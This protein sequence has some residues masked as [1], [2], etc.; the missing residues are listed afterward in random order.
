M[1]ELSLYPPKKHVKCAKIAGDTSGNYHPHGEAVIYPTLVHM[2]Q[3]WAMRETLDRSAGELRLGGRRPSGGHALHRGAHDASRRHADAGH[4]EGHGR[5]RAQLRRAPHRADR[6]SRRRSRTSSSMAAPA[7]RSAWRRTCRRTTSAKSST[8]VCAQIDNPEITADGAHGAHQG[9]GLPHGLHHS[10]HQAAS[11][12]TWRPATARCASAA[13]RR[14]SRTATA[15]RS[16]SPRSRYNVNR[17]ELVEAHRRSWR[18]RRSSRKSAACATSR[19]RTS[20]VVVD[21][22][23]DARAAGGAQ[24]PLQ[25]H[26]AGDLASA[27]TC[28]RS[29][30]AR[31]R[32]LS[33]KDAIACY[34]EH[35]REVII[36]R[37][38]FLL[39]KAEVQAEKLE[40]FLLALGHLDDFIKIIRDSSNR[41]EARAGLQGLHLHRPRPPSS[42]ASSSAA[43]RAF[44]TAATSSPTSRSTTSSNC[45]STSSPAWSATR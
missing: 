29:T 35:R 25:A 43:S 13:W 22:K 33:M 39:G 15:S 1:H 12:N 26:R 34:I 21:L 45:A 4:G 9:S 42:S 14:S 40:A 41:D 19:T 16:S 44:R 18:T 24:Q 11:A 2:G 20:R 17:A 28:S 38:R 27:S 7:S 6:V 5:F 23:K 8:R 31:P 10:R 36:R 32:V 3:Q 37:T 30:A